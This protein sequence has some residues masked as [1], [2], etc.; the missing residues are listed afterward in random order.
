MKFSSKFKVNNER[1]NLFFLLGVSVFLKLLYSS[2]RS[3]GLFNS[4]PDA[5]G[6][7]PIAIAFS[8][9][10]FTSPVGGIPFYPSGYPFLLSV[11]IRLVGD[12]WI[13]AAQV[14]QILLFSFAALLFLT[15]I[16][17]YFTRDIAWISFLVLV[18]NPAW[19]VV[20]GEAMYE[21]TLASF[22]IIS[23]WLIDGQQSTQ[24]RLGA[25]RLALGGLI[26]GAAIVVHPRVLL[27]Y[28]IVLGCLFVSKKYDTRMKLLLL[29][30]VSVLPIIFSTRNLIAQKQFTLMSSFWDAQSFNSFLSGCR[31]SFCAL[32]RIREDSVG[33]LSQCFLNAI[34]FWSPHSGPLEKGTWYHNIS[35]LSRLNRPWF[36]ISAIVL[37]LLFS[38]LV[39]FSWV[40][41]T[42][43]LLSLNRTMT[44]ILLA[45]SFSFWI[46][47]ILVY[48]ENR[49]RLIALLFMLPSHAKFMQFLYA[50]F[51]LWK[52]KVGD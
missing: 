44:V 4:G 15:L 38:I 12:G 34:S 36:G 32:T 1:T 42:K 11:L 23:I 28:S 24:N 48:G 35:L 21:T 25:L 5:N 47:D 39:F 6:Y 13:L 30:A 50:Q 3:V 14:A 41:G 20:N 7:I 2:T 18:F 19:F 22:F 46:T 26:S 33:F 31:S 10:S 16:C 45:L 49:H 29:G 40:L 37:S 27:S 9:K 43:L 8:E 52:I 17:R 51:S